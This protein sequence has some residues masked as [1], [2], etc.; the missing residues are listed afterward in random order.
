MSGSTAH[1]NDIPGVLLHLNL[2]LDAL[3]AVRGGDAANATAAL[4]ER[5]RILEGGPEGGEVGAG[6][7][8]PSGPRYGVPS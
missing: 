7:T 2:A 5:G 6:F 8:V 4:K 3:N 1:N